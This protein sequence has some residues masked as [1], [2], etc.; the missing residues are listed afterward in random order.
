VEA[1][2][3]AAALPLIPVMLP[4]ACTNEGRRDSD[5]SGSSQDRR[6][7]GFSRRLSRRAAQR[8]G[9]TLILETSI[10]LHFPLT[11]AG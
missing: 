9:L 8:L 1:R 5:Q 7:R 2:A 4:Y 6:G 3:A 10:C 11:L